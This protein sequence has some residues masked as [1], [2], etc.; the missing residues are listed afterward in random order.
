MFQQMS[1][2]DQNPPAGHGRPSRPRR[3]TMPGGPSA[4]SAS[5]E[6]AGVASDI[7]KRTPFQ[8]PRV[9]AYVNV[10]RTASLFSADFERLFRSHGLS[11][12]TYN[13]LRILRGS[14]LADPAGLGEVTCQRIGEQMVSPVPDVTRLVDRLER[15]GLARRRRCERDRRVVYVSITPEGES[16]LDHLAP[17]VDDQHAAHCADMTE[18]DLRRLS[19]LLTAFRA[20]ARSTRG[21][22]PGQSNPNSKD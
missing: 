10:I 14:K 13:V 21:V 22:R 3:G 11:E 19:A 9:E 18:A 5:T 16:L 8:C 20:G 15:Q 6:V 17:G 2:A 12:A 7:G 4:P 1:L